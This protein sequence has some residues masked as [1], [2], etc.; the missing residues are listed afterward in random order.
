MSDKPI[1]PPRPYGRYTELLMLRLSPE[2]MAELQ[3]VKR[4]W[5]GAKAPLGGCARR[6]LISGMERERIRIER[7]KARRG[8]L[9]G[10]SDGGSGA[11]T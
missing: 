7:E 9:L 8:E 3:A 2:Q 4:E 1:I 10:H 6:L 5:H 11:F